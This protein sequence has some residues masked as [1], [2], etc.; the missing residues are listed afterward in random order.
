MRRKGALSWD[1][2]NSGVFETD[3]L[4]FFGGTPADAAEVFREEMAR[5]GAD[6]PPFPDEYPEES[7]QGLFITFDGFRDC[8][9]WFPG[10]LQGAEG[11]GT[12]AHE[13]VHAACHVLARCGVQYTSHGGP[14]GEWINDEPW[15]Y[16]VGWLVKNIF[17]VSD[18]VIKINKK[19]KTRCQG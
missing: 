11:A 6:I 4:I 2:V 3:I 1:W 5:Q 9:L 13:S 19:G 7:C 14:S 10:V 17:K 8:A 12:A 16:F 15:S 18:E